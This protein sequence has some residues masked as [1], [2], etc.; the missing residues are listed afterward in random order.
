MTDTLL[1]TATRAIA[2][3]SFCTLATASDASRP[4]IAGVLYSAAGRTLYVSTFR[5]SRKA[6]NVAVNPRVAVTVPVRRLPVG[7][8]AAVQFQGTAR[9]LDNDDP[10]IRELAAA[11]RLKAISG[12]GEL[13]LDGGCVLR[14]EPGRR[15]VTFG[16]G[17]PLLRFLRDPL[18]AAGA[19]D[20]PVEP[21]A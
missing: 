7:P 2:K 9:I 10:E 14:I 17:M 20:L 16:L 11:G 4:H 21:A 8:P 19:V 1:A 6:R 15:M 12:H 5:D 18:N 13:E 3:R